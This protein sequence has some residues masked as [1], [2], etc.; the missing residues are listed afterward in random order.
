M[1]A[2]EADG[3]PPAEV[4]AVLAHRA[5]EVLGPLRKLDRH[6]GQLFLSQFYLQCIWEAVLLFTLYVFSLLVAIF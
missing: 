2:P 1:S 5:A 3:R 6:L 4:E